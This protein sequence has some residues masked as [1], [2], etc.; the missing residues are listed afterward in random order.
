M[1]F[2]LK[3]FA[4][5]VVWCGGG[6]SSA[7]GACAFSCPL[8]LHCVFCAAAQ[9]LGLVFPSLPV[10]ASGGWGSEC[11]VTSASRRPQPRN[12]RRGV[13]LVRVVSQ[14]EREVFVFVFCLGFLSVCVK[15]KFYFGLTNPHASRW[16]LS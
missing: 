10:F 11:E 7:T 12:R 3:E 1:L 5:T 4:Y 6:A 15:A 16:F 13:R 14:S 8:S 2:S 9:L